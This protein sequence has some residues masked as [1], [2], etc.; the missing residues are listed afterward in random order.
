MKTTMLMAVTVAI[1]MAQ[2]SSVAEYTS[3]GKMKLPPNYREWVYLSSGLGMTYGPAGD[4][5]RERAPMFDNVFV[6]PASYQSFLKTGTWPD[7]TT[8]I[9]EIRGSVSRGSINNGGRYQS[10]VV[11]IEAEVKDAARYGGSGW[12]F[13][14]FGREN[15]GKLFPSSAACY[16]CHPT[17]GAVDNTFVQFYPTLLPVAKAKGTLNPAY[18]AAEDG[19]R[20]D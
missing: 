2:G 19:E 8:F 20:K 6:N 5:N 18:V 4:E 9:L 16:T 1:L 14:A 17:K 3:D 12:A 7:K 15:T 10:D 13:F 11:A